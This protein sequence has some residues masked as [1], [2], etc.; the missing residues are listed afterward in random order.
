MKYRFM[1]FPDFKC[2]ALTLSYDDANVNDIR[3]AKLLHEH[4]IKCTFNVPGTDFP[5]EKHGWKITEDD[6]REIYLP[7]GHDVAL[8]GATHTTPYLTAPK[9]GMMEFMRNRAFLEK[10][11]GRIVR[12]MAYPDHG[13]TTEEIKTYLRMMGITFARSV[14]TTHNFELPADWLRWEMTVHNTEAC[15]FDLVDKF[16]AKKPNDEY[17]SHRESLV[18]SMWGHSFEFPA[19]DFK[20]ITAFCE[21]MG[22]RDDIWYVTNNELYEYVKAY[23]S[24]VFSQENTFVYN[25]TQIGVWMDVDKKEYYIAPGETLYFD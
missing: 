22:G 11:F 18:F 7:L 14:G 25:P 20:G 15:L 17:I 8:H 3:L 13:G 10:F 24:L 1:R 2:K 16:L 9:D 19:D 6:A 23:E 4:G 21:K 12:G 5:K